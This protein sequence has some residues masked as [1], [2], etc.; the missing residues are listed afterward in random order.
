M[1]GGSS[2]RRASGRRPSSRDASSRRALAALFFATVAV[3]SDLYI[4][5]PLLPLLS[6]EFGVPAPTA[7]LTL[8]VVVLMIALVSNAWGPLA[9]SFGRKPVMVGSCVL[10]ALPTFLCAAAPTLPALIALRALQGALVPG[11]TAVAVA[12]LGDQFAGPALGPAV[13]SWVAA[14]VTGGLTGRVASGWIAS[15][16]SWRAP[17]VVFGAFTLAGALAMA[18]FLPPSPRGGP[19]SVG[20]AFREM[21]GHLR[22]RRLVGGFLIGGS[23]FF[24]FIGIFTYLPYYLSAPPFGLSTGTISAIYLVYG[25]GVLTSI[26]VGRLSGRFGRRALM[27]TGFLIAAFAATLSLVRALPV[28]IL[29]LVVLCVGM[30]FVQ[31][32]APAF[33]NATA[34]GA[35]GGAGALYTT[36]YY[37]GA[38]FGSVLP[39][40]AWQAFGWPGVVTACLGA[41]GVGLLADLILC[42]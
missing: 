41:F 31:G 20:I 40:Y 17:F 38:T 21:L 5:Q 4:T 28:V 36:F 39:G 6:R 22:D 27:A 9:D 25:A 8:S 14:S 34:R 19:V 24:G 15:H 29:S 35:K 30:F 26:A 12:Y 23:V 32:T 2:G 42:A 7:A 3:F 33:V 37:V 10:L 13:G 11:V 1:S 18:L 16:L